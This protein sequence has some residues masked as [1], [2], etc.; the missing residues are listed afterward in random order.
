VENLSMNIVFFCQSCGA[1]FEVSSASAGRKGR[2]KSCGQLMTI[3]RAQELASMVA[4][5]ALPSDAVGAEAGAAVAKG[6][7]RDPGG[8]NSLAWLAA[9]PID[10]ALAP[11][12]L[13]T[14]PVGGAR[15]PIKPEYD[16]DLGDSE[17]YAL[18][19]P[20]VSTSKGSS[21]GRPASGLKVLWRRELGIVQRLFRWLN[22]TAYLVS[23]PFVLMVLLGAIVGSRPLALAGATAVVLLNIGRIVAGV[24]NLAVV[25]FRE[26]ILRGI[27]F[28]IPPL[29]FLY[30]SSHWKQLKKP[31][32]RI[33]GPIATIA[34]VFVAFT[35]IP[36]LRKD[37][38]MA[39][40][41]DLKGEIRNEARELEGE[42]VGELEKARN[43]DVQGLEKKAE[44]SLGDAAGKINWIGQ[45]GAT[46]KTP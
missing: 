40:L 26:G 45:P 20:L 28:L 38:R 33:I 9:A 8:G 6:A 24:A 7:S 29:T 39:S 15:R 12:T 19:K 17:P 30:L 16:D 3:P 13:D 41:K 42:M 27:M 44:K 31:T 46:G 43:L 4:L 10:V 22:E 14:L 25:P 18:G 2:C 32:M 11:L 5:Q 1:R 37:H 35:F 23:V 34:V 21:G 36:T